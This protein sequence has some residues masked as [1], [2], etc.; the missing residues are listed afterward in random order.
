LECAVSATILALVL[1]QALSIYCKSTLAKN[2]VKRLVGA[3]ELAAKIQVS[4]RDIRNTQRKERAVSRF[5]EGRGSDDEEK[6]EAW[7]GDIVVQSVSSARSKKV[8][9][10]VDLEVSSVVGVSSVFESVD[11]QSVMSVDSV[12]GPG[13]ARVLDRADAWCCPCGV[14]CARAKR[15]AHLHECSA[16]KDAWRSAV[17]EFLSTAGPDASARAVD[18]VARQ[19]RCSADVALCALAE[20]RGLE[21]LAISK[22]SHAAYRAEVTVVEVG[23]FGDF[24]RA[25][26]GAEETRGEAP[27]LRTPSAARYL[28]RTSDPD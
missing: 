16:F 4:A 2:A 27:V 9:P 1:S 8:Y 15:E 28:R 6:K 20:S 7:A 19:A 12:R 10:E 5:S 24:N 17:V 23:V 14:R 3:G 25:Q 18:E 26:A 11:H 22:L 13:A 21:H